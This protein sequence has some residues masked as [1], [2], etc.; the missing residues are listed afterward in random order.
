MY[1]KF[2]ALLVS[3][4]LPAGCHSWRQTNSTKPLKAIRYLLT[5]SFC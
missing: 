5:S 3:V 2:R 1:C 4:I